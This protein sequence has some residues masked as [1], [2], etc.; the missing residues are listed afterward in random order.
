MKSRRTKTNVGA[1]IIYTESL[2]IIEVQENI[3]A[4]MRWDGKI[5][6]IRHQERKKEG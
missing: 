2:W 3:W 1:R 5:K 6:T 4:E